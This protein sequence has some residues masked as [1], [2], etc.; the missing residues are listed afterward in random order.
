MQSLTARFV[1]LCGFYAFPSDSFNLNK[2]FLLA[3][4]YVSVTVI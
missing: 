3:L 1:P 4:M 2:N